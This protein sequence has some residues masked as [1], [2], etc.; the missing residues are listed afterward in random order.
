MK[1]SASPHELIDLSINSPVTNNSWRCPKCSFDNHP[2]LP[3][4]EVCDYSFLAVKTPSNAS[5]PSLENT[6]AIPFLGDYSTVPEKY[7]ENISTELFRQRGETTGLIPLLDNFFARNQIAGALCSRCS[8]FT[9]L[10][11]YGSKWS[12]GYRNIQMLCSTLIAIPTYRRVLFNG[13]GVVPSIEVLQQW[14]E[15]AWS[16]GF[17]TE[18]TLIYCSFHLA[19]DLLFFLLPL[20]FLIRGL[21]T[22]ILNCLVLITGS[23]QQVHHHKSLLTMTHNFSIE[24]AT[25]LRYFGLRAVIVD[26]AEINSLNHDNSGGSGVATGL[27]RISPYIEDDNKDIWKGNA[28]EIEESDENTE[29]ITSMGERIARWVAKY[30]LVYRDRKAESTE[31]SKRRTAEKVWKFCTL[32]MITLICIF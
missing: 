27:N 26:F 1:R 3:T 22:L 17:D 31:G 32:A 21:R 11:T 16:D 30:F 5:A 25:L 6:T 23:A 29:L 28:Q 8:H 7:S 24:C 10:G 19:I 2:D 13:S 4:C 14:I 15:K 9:Q 20:A 12:C 18:V